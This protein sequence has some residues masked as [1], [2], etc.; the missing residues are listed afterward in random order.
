MAHALQQA[1]GT[2]TVHDPQAVDTA[3]IRNP[4]LNYANELAASV[5]GADIVIL[6]TERSEYQQA[7][8]GALVDR[9]ANPLLVD[10][11]TAGWNRPPARTPRQVER[12]PCIGGSRTLSTPG[13]QEASRCGPR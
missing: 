5:N 10:C 12:G 13:R 7:N 2:V 9:P 6:A 3:V 4:E 1:G 11:R 8:P